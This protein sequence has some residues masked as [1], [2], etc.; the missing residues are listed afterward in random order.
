MFPHFG[1]ARIQFHPAIPGYLNCYLDSVH[2]CLPFLDQTELQVLT[3]NL[4]TSGS[5]DSSTLLM[6]LAIG[7]ALTSSTGPVSTYHAFMLFEASLEKFDTLL[8]SSSLSTLQFLLLTCIFSL[9][10]PAGGSTWHL[11]GL[12]IQVVITLGLHHRR[13]S[14]TH[15]D[16]GSMTDNIFW[17]VYI[18]D[19]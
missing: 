11:L 12:A 18:L 19:R 1:A 9:Y 10:N 6:V 14:S 17:C 7:A 4:Q 5:T 16:D 3:Q 8:I 15:M 2:T 13:G